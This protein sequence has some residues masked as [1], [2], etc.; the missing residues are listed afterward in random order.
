[1][2]QPID[3]QERVLALRDVAA[4]GE[5]ALLDLAR[6]IDEKD[7]Y[8]FGHSERVCQYALALGRAMQLSEERVDLLR[9]AALLHDLGKVDVPG[10]ILRKPG[11]LTADEFAEVQKHPGRAYELLMQVPFLAPV[12]PAVRHHHERFDGAGYPDGL[13]GGAI[14]LEARVLAVVDAYDAMVS[15]R[16]YRRALAVDDALDQIRRGAGTQFD[17]VC[18]ATFVKTIRERHILRAGHVGAATFFAEVSIREYERAVRSGDLMQIDGEEVSLFGLADLLLMDFPELTGEQAEKVVRAVLFPE[19]R[20]DDLYSHDVD[21][22]KADEVRVRFPAR[23]D[24]DVRSIVCFEG[25]LYTI[26][27]LGELDDGRF[28]Y[29]LKR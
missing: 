26:V 12:A 29:H 2:G 19:T 10:E 21:R 20:R 17:P 14:P 22:V 27:D 25:E 1:M 13:V 23:I 5:H 9:D 11:R 6:T 15:N 8:T 28:E 4:Q 7:L 16:P 3:L 24:A 18:A